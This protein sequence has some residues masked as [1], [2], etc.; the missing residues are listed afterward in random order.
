MIGREDKISNDL[1]FTCSLIAYISRKTLNKPSDIVDYLGYENINKIYSLA[2]VYHSDNIEKVSNDFI[3]TCNIAAGDFDNISNCKYSVPTHFD[4]GKVYKRLILMAA[5][6][7]GE[8]IVRTLIDVYHSF[9]CDLIEDYNS[10]FYYDNPQ[11]IYSTYKNGEVIK[12]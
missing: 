3:K 11:T 8:D 5:N 2:D 12:E 4:I 6:D 9:I 7:T 10:S 1:F